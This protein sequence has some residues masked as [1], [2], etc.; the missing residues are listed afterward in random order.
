[1]LTWDSGKTEPKYLRTTIVGI[2]DYDKLP[3]NNA[4]LV[5]KL[6]TGFDIDIFIGFNR[7]RGINVDSKKANDKV[8]IIEAGT[9]GQVSIASDDIGFH[10][11]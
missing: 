8:T 5:V 1:M 7:A 11:T 6:E 10:I 3:S 4:A 2:A 9:N